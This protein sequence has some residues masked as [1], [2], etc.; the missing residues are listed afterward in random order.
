MSSAVLFCD[1]ILEVEL[2]TPSQ[3]PEGALEVEFGEYTFL[4]FIHSP[5]EGAEKRGI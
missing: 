3:V 1:S 2:S 5:C 4:P